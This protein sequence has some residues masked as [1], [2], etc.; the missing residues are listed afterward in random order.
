M[1]IFKTYKTYDEILPGFLAARR[2][3][4]NPRTYSCDFGKVAVFS[5]WLKDN[6]LSSVPLKKLTNQQIASF[7]A[8]LAT[9]KQLDRSTLQKYFVVIRMVWQYAFK[10]KEYTERDLPFDLVVFPLKHIDS[11]PDLIP[12]EI[13]VPLT[14]AMRMKDPMIYLAAMLE[15]YAFIRPR[16]EVRKLRTEYFN[17]GNR[18]IFIPE[19]KTKKARYATI[20]PE[21]MEILIWYGLDKAPSGKYIFCRKG[22]FGDNYVSVNYFEYHF[23]KFKKLF[24]LPKRCVFYSFKHTGIT[25]MLNNGVALKSV[26]EQAGHERLSS[27]QH[28][29]KKYASGPNAD[30]L[31]YRRDPLPVSPIPML[32]HE[33]AYN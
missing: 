18:S 1:N 26:M 29:A 4:L 13:F 27:T 7:F 24:N 28:Y 20:T 3:V 23:D 16:E 9:D 31:K 33:I 32:T 6:Q 15:Y 2:I 12:K 11:S 8:H 25:D 10:I 5:D 17:L 21:L 22:I 19:T 30:M 14:Q